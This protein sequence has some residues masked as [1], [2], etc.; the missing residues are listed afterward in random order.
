[1]KYQQL[2]TRQDW[3][4][5]NSPILFR[6]RD[7]SLAKTSGPI[8]AAFRKRAPP[9][10]IGGQGAE[11]GRKGN[12]W[13]FWGIKQKASL[14]KC[15]PTSLFPLPIKRKNLNTLTFM[16]F[17]RE[18][19]IGHGFAT[20]EFEF[21]TQIYFPFEPIPATPAKPQNITFHMSWVGKNH[22]ATS[23]KRKE[24]TTLLCELE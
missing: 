19:S 18:S 6:A 11:N 16:R 24:A 8:R 5:S 2:S 7:N 20:S 14:S 10:L 3:T 9:F 22:L 12:L 13:S 17:A 23:A 4:T 21:F 1:M 15:C